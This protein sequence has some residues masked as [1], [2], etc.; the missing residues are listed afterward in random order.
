MGCLSPL[1]GGFHSKILAPPPKSIAIETITN[2]SQV[3]GTP[4]AQANADDACANSATTLPP[5]REERCVEWKLGRRLEAVALY[6]DF[7]TLGI[8]IENTPCTSQ[9][10][11]ELLGEQQLEQLHAH[12]QPHCIDHQAPP[13]AELKVTIGSKISYWRLENVVDRNADGETRLYSYLV[14]ITELKLAQHRAEL[15]HQVVDSIPSWVFIKNTDHNY[16]F[17]NDAYAATYQLTPDQCVGKNSIDLGVP[18][19]IAMGS[20][21][22]GIRGFWQDDNDVFESGQPKA[23]QSEPIVVGGEQRV[24]QTLKTPIRDPHTGEQLIV[25]FCHDITYLKEVESRMWLELRHNKTLNQISCLLRTNDDSF[26]DARSQICELLV[27]QLD[28]RA[29]HIDAGATPPYMPIRPDVVRIQVPIE[30]KCLRL[31]TLTVDFDHDDKQYGTHASALIADVADRLAIHLYNCQLITKENFLA[32]HDSMTGLPN[33]HY[34]SSKLAS[35]SKRAIR[36]G[37]LC[38]VALLD[39]DGFKQINDSLGHHVGDHLLEAVAKRLKGIVQPNEFLA[40]LG[41]D[42]FAI[43]ISD[44]ENREAGVAASERFLEAIQHPFEVENRDLVVGASCGISFFSDDTSG[45]T[46]MLQR[47]DSAMYS[48]KASGRNILQKFTQS[49]AEQTNNRLQLEQGLQRA[50]KNEGELYL[51]FQPKHDLRT[52][53]ATGVEALVRWRCA[54]RGILVMPSEF[55]PVAE[56]SGLILQ[57]SDWIMNTAFSTI[58]SWNEKLRSPCELSLNV[59]LPELEQLDFSERILQCLDAHQFDPAFL[60]LEVTETFMM[61]HFEQVSK[62]LGVLRENGIKI[63]LDDFGTGYSCMSYLQHLPADALKIDRSF[64]SVLD[65]D[66]QAPQPKQIAISEAIVALAKSAGLKTVAE[67][68]ETENQLRHAVALDID[69]GQGYFFNKPLDESDAFQI[70]K[71][72]ESR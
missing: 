37:E 69:F 23:I 52:G 26:D 28:C 56:E 32:N 1:F 72:Q 58:T 34:F 31:G 67:G 46:S 11:Q 59:A 22:K 39:L 50:M 62:R 47:A 41:G 38:A 68:I 43:L 49:I 57:L 19:E 15:L 48:A 18:A 33:R 16:E 24:L 55:I 63:S 51:V 7:S 54:Q 4:A 13:Q 65:F 27:E 53:L 35:T 71:Q 60:D 25:G 70:F 66:P 14:D 9:R 45:Q 8:G 29:V 42:E 44:L 21:E 20:E 3:L 40:R 5:R 17:V 64:V 61:K 36:N 2:H 30:L 12:F 10:F 6:G